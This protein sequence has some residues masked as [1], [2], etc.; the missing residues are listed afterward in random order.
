[1][2]DP[3]GGLYRFGSYRL[4]ATSR[5]LTRSGLAVTLA[6]KTFD[7]L[8]L[9]AESG[10]RLLSKREL[11]E[12]LWKGA[13]VEEAN[14]SFQMSSLRKALGEEGA[15]WFEAVPKYGYRFTAPLERPAAREEPHPDLIR[16]QF[17]EPTV[18]PTR[19]QFWR[20]WSIPAIAGVLAIVI[21][22]AAWKRWPE[23]VGRRA[24]AAMH[25]IPA[26]AYRGSEINPTL[27]PDG[28]QLAFAW[29][30]ESGNNFDIYVKVV[31]DNRALRLTRDPRLEFSPVWSPDGRRIAFCREGEVGSEVVLI[32]ALGGPER[33]VASLPIQID[34]GHP[35]SPLLSRGKSGQ[36]SKQL[37]WFPDGRFLAVVGRKYRGGPNT[38]FLLSVDDGEMRPL[39]SPRDRTWG[40]GVPAVSPDGHWLSFARSTAKYSDPAHLYFMPLSDRKTAAGAVRQVTPQE[41]DVTGL[42]WTSDGQ[43]LVFP[44]QRGLWSVTLHGKVPEPLMLP[45]YNPRYPAISAEGHRLAFV[46]SY[47]KNLDIRRV[48]GPTVTNKRSIVAHPAPTR[49]VSSTQLDTNPQYSPD[50]SRIAF[51]STRSG[52]QEIWVCDSDGSNPVRLTD[53]KSDTGTPRWSPDGRY[54]AFDSARSESGDIYVVPAQ[55]GPVRNITPE[56]SHEDMASWSHDGRWIYFESNRTGS[57]EIWKTPASGGTAVQVTRNGGAEAFESGDGKFVYYTKWGLPGI[58][59]K[60]VQGGRETLV[61]HNGRPYH[62]GLFDKGVCSLDIEA[63]GSPTINCLDLSSNQVTTVWALPK[64][65]LVNREGP[66][67]SISHDGRWMLYVGVDRLESDIM[68]I[69]NFR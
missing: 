57:Y 49:L 66:S 5:V 11:M 63:A 1:M 18:P 2:S 16:S 56:S 22:F 29:D 50:A 25:V 33:I 40:D 8:V 45:G 17:V 19:S 23:I 24:D 65:T 47:T 30:G 20:V 35:A 59:R 67:F 10:G 21:A 53:L 7:L 54:L 31:G 14:L 32:P 51:T 46:D 4:D 64:G 13:F 36:F 27:S 52:T 28:S 58:W 9:M 34:P 41:T 68:V 26:T 3:S 55:G 39:T 62:W 38:I 48:G 6:P 69:E 15:A 42:A 43:R 60:P 61:V 12:K 37:S 44:S